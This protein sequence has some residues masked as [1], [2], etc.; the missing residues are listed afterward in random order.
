MEFTLIN[1][2]TASIISPTNIVQQTD[3]EIIVNTNDCWKLIQNV[4]EDKKYP[5]YFKEEIPDSPEYRKNNNPALAYS[6]NAGSQYT[7]NLEYRFGF[8]NLFVGTKKIAPVS[9]ALSIPIDVTAGKKITISCTIL[10]P[11]AGSVEFYIIDN[12]DEIPILPENMTNVVK[13]QLFFGLPT[14]FIIDSNIPFDLYEDNVLTSKSYVGL[15]SKEF[16]DH[17]YALSYTPVENVT[18]YIPTSDKIRIKVIIRQYDPVISI[19][20]KDFVIHKYGETLQ[21]SL[22]Q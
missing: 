13:E 11:E 19:A 20:I 8:H 6:D 9:G 5:E 7:E 17:T 3:D 14:R 12:T 22:N 16:Q 21:W 10:H 18:E 1:K 15:S 2:D 4:Q